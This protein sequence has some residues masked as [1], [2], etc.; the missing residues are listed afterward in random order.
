MRERNAMLTL[1]AYFLIHNSLKIV[2]VM[3][4]YTY[5]DLWT[6]ILS[7]IICYRNKNKLHSFVQSVL[8]NAEIKIRKPVSA[9]NYNNF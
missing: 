1:A 5:N 3:Y 6:K 2:F 4:M 7:A 9:C 8:H